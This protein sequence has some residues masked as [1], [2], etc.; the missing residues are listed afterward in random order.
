MRHS[1][2]TGFQVFGGESESDIQKIL[3]L[4]IQGHAAVGLIQSCSFRATRC[5]Q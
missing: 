3:N 1:G 5:R 4:S 2:Q